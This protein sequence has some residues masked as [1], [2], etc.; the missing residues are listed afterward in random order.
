ML[1][2]V[3]NL[4]LEEWSHLFKFLQNLISS[5]HLN[6]S[7]RMQGILPLVNL[8][9]TYNSTYGLQLSKE[10]HVICSCSKIHCPVV[11][12]FTSIII[13]VHRNI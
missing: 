8:Q 11:Y 4:I 12:Y 2:V 10:I 5:G 13:I 9:G 6:V 7:I 1:K 3:P